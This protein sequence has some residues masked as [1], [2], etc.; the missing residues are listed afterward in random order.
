MFQLY[1]TLPLLT[2]LFL[3]THVNGYAWFAFGV[4]AEGISACCKIQFKIR[5]S[6]ARDGLIPGDNNF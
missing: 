4:T 1:S 2:K 6:L 5:S 3:H